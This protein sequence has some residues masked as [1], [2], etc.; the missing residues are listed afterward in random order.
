VTLG[1]LLRPARSG[2]LDKQDKLRPLRLVSET[3]RIKEEEE[4]ARK[5]ANRASWICSSVVVHATAGSRRAGG[6]PGGSCISV[7]ITCDTRGPR[8]SGGMNNYTGAVMQQDKLRPLRL[9]SETTRIKEGSCCD[10]PDRAGW[11]WRVRGSC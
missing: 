3:T 2:W 11:T 6:S 1:E 5:K 10:R 7:R 4:A 9:V 8:S